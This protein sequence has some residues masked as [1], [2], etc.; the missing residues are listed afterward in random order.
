MFGRVCQHQ[1]LGAELVSNESAAADFVPLTITQLAPVRS[2]PQ[3][4]LLWLHLIDS[5]RSVEKLLQRRTTV[6]QDY[7]LRS[8]R[9]RARRNF[10]W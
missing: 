2:L 8:V 4:N 9:I 1:S 6:P 7:K 10:F 5:D 3:V